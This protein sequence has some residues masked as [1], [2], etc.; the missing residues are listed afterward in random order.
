MAVL[1][2]KTPARGG[3]GEPNVAALLTLFVP[4]LG[5]LYLGRPALAAALFVSIEGLYLLGF[6]LSDGLLFAFL[7]PELRGPLA[8]MLTPE[9]G[10]VGMLLA[11]KAGVLAEHVIGAGYGE[12]GPA[13]PIPW[14]AHMRL[15]V[16]LTALSGML[17]ALAAV[18]A[19]LDA[20]VG[21][22]E[23]ARG[24]APALLLAA[25]FALPGLG[26]LLQGRRRRGLIVLA[27]LVGL[28][29]LGTFLAEGS[30][31]SRERHFY[32]WAG[33]FLLGGPALAAEAAFGA[34]RVRGPIPWADAGLL[35]GCVAGL[36]NVLA[37]IDVYGWEEARLLGEDPGTRAAQPAPVPAVVASPPAEGE[38]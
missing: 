35:F 7:D 16:A 33:Q 3:G 19:H 21:A 38:R 24:R 17:N 4:G 30:N 29:A 27:A 31:L 32:Y 8:S 28:F 1:R 18:R 36:L 15:G 34:M 10:N 5:H 14:P 11:H 2:E 20:R 6:W 26:H 37:L 25:G 12:Y 13:D 9:V 22:V 23:R